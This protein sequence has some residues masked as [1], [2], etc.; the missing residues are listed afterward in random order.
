M[1]VSVPGE[2]CLRGAV[3]NWEQKGGEEREEEKNEVMK[4]S[5]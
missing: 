3:R 5:V 1:G 2:L 4:G